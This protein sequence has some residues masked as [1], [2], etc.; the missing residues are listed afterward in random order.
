MR[1]EL[2]AIDLE[3][4]GLD[5]KNDSIIEIGAVRLADG[6]IVDEFSQLIDPGFPI[7]PNITHITGIATEQVVGQPKIDAVL[8]A[9]KAF[10][11]DAPIIGH[12]ID[13]DAGFMVRHGA[14]E[15]NL[16]LDTYDLAAVL[17][18]RTPRYN[19]NSL[20]A[21][22][23]IDLEHAHRALDDARAT[24]L[25][26]WMLWQKALQ[27]P[28]ATLHEIVTAARGL[29]WQAE[30]VFEAALA[31]VSPLAADADGPPDLSGKAIFGTLPTDEKPLRPFDDIDQ[32]DPAAV[33]SHID[34][35]G[36]LAEAI[37]GYDKRPQQIDMA[38]AVTEA[39][40]H[41][42]HLMIEAGTGTGK[43]IAYLVPAA[44]WATTNNQ[45][46]VISTNTINLQEQLLE[47]DLPILRQA[48]K[49]PFK[50]TVL[51]GARQLPVSAPPGRHPSSPTHQR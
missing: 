2:V 29:N 36:A 21:E 32:L 31:E 28:H 38:R 50:A 34:D 43:S 48:L 25:L 15:A 5:V 6:Q 18:P 33:T 11:G 12:N 42:H 49:I 40:N 10:V 51:K 1:G 17:L 24:G 9:I 46:V 22:M 23:G 16:R 3:T 27:L 41:G 30:P 8:P 26:Y 37:P 7:P 39:F 13:F 35:G 45:R 4:T 20:T 19:L 44:L 14:L 47:K